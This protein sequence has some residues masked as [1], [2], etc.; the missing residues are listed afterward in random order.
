MELSFLSFPL[1]KQKILNYQLIYA[2]NINNKTNNQKT[3]ERVQEMKTAVVV[4]LGW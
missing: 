3:S 1:Q 4:L 2:I